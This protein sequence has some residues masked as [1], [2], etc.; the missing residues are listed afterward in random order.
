MERYVLHMQAAVGHIGHQ[1]R[2]KLIGIAGCYPQPDRPAGGLPASATA[3]GGSSRSRAFPM[4][5]NIRPAARSIPLQ[6]G[7]FRA[8]AVR[9]RIGSLSPRPGRRLRPDAHPAAETY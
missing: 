7:K 8:R 4:A 9:I 2:D 3:T 6:D 1:V 5:Q